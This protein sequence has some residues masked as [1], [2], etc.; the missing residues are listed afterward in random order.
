MV[1]AM[2]E[3]LGDYQKYVD[4][5]VS[6]NRLSPSIGILLNNALAESHLVHLIRAILPG[7]T[8]AHS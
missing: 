5:S 7:D 4:C 6:K 2:R 8:N 3:T 1:A